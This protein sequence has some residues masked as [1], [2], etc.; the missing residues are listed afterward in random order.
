LERKL[1]RLVSFIK[2]EDLKAAEA[3][4]ARKREVHMLMKPELHDELKRLAK[5]N[6][7]TVTRLVTGIVENALKE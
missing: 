5:S 1:D 3:K 4:T 2:L 7:L 6:G